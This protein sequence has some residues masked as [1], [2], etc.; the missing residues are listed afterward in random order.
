VYFL[1]V[2]TVGGGGNI[3]GS[4]WAALLLGVADMAGKYYVPQIGAFII[5][6]IMVVILIFRPQGLFGR[7]HQ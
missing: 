1:I 7:A 3:L 4:L 2:V 5:Y 6:A